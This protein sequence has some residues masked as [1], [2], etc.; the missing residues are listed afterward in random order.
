MHD[1]TLSP[2]LKVALANQPGQPLRVMDPDT[3]AAYVL[4]DAVAFD[5]LAG[6]QYDDSPWTDE[7]KHLL[8]A[9]AGSCIGWD[10][11]SEYDHYP[12]AKS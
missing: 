7:E 4:I 11:M 6:N 9:E 8:A 3:R 1:L 2:A 12:D 10:E 5:H